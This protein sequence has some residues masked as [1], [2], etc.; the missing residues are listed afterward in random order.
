MGHESAG[1]WQWLP[2]RQ[3]IWFV[4]GGASGVCRSANH[5][6]RQTNN[7]LPMQ[8]QRQVML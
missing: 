4:L 7:I 1:C 6:T 8:R 5:A 3:S 2:S